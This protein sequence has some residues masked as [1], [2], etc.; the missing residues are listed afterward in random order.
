MKTGPVLAFAGGLHFAGDLERQVELL[1]LVERVQQKDHHD[2]ADKHG[3]GS[4]DPQQQREGEVVATQPEGEEVLAPVD[5][6]VHV[7]GRQTWR[8]LPHGN[9]EQEAGMACVPD[10]L[11]MANEREQK[12]EQQAEVLESGGDIPGL[13]INKSLQ[14]L[15]GVSRC[16]AD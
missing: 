11:H 3:D 6:L 8:V 1:G 13:P 10:G 14:C 16:T 9:A 15:T 7:L 5:E 12:A 4:K 2:R